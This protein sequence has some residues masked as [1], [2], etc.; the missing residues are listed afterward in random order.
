MVKKKTKKKRKKTG[1]GGD[2]QE[3][4]AERSKAYK[5]MHMGM[6]VHT[7]AGTRWLPGCKASQKKMGTTNAAGRKGNT[8]RTLQEKCW[9]CYVNRW[10]HQ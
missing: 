5:A 3:T 9:E 10:E 8:T 2:A 4:P 7:V 1:E 6:R